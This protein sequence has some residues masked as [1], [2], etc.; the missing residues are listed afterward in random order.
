MRDNVFDTRIWRS[1]KVSATLP[2]NLGGPQG[3]ESNAVGSMPMSV[4]AVLGMNRT[5][6]L[7]I[8]GFQR[9]GAPVELQ[10]SGFWLLGNGVALRLKRHPMSSLE[11]RSYLLIYFLNS[12]AFS[13]FMTASYIRILF[14]LLVTLVDGKKI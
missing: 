13:E 2:V 6:H 12:Y 7:G 3:K 10:V 4:E 9:S 1:P 14:V 5:L 11:H 8:C